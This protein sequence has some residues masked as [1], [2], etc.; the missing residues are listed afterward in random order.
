MCNSKLKSVGPV[1]LS[2][3]L[4]GIG[5]CS[6][7]TA[8]GDGPTVPMRPVEN[9]ALSEEYD[10]MPTPSDVLA[11]VIPRFAGRYVE[12]GVVKVLIAGEP[13]SQ[14]EGESARSAVRLVLDSIGQVGRK[15]EF[16]SGKYDFIQFRI[17]EK[18]LSKLNR[19]VGMISMG[20]QQKNQR[21]W[22]QVTSEDGKRKLL[23]SLESLHIPQEAV[24]VEVREQLI[25]Y[26]TTI[27]KI[28]P[29]RAGSQLTI[30][31]G[32]S[33]G[34]TNV[35]TSGFNVMHSVQV[36]VLT[37]AHCVVG[38]PYPFGGY[39]ADQRYNQPVE[40]PFNANR[41]ARV[42]HNPASSSSLPG[43][44]PGDVCRYSDAA[45]AII[46]SPIGDFDLFGMIRTTNRELV[47]GVAGSLNINTSSPRIPVVG[48]FVYSEGDTIDKIGKSTGWTAGEVIAECV[49]AY[50]AKDNGGRLCSGAVSAGS[51]PGD[52]G[53]PVFIWD[54][55]ENTAL[56]VGILFGGG[57]P[58][59]SGTSDHFLFSPVAGINQDFSASFP[60][61]FLFGY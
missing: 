14:L 46:T 55:V 13:L 26:Q 11:T 8:E 27:S 5:A 39:A 12:S 49:Y 51:G 33:S 54:S 57:V 22:I 24:N 25:P 1:I 41:F 44:W 42:T 37:V 56:A 34:S 9:V 36:Y 15:F 40:A 60:S 30:R 35:C 23:N 43:C 20:L 4:F 45:A 2:L 19:D 32:P 52:S 17:W 31:Y 61:G 7:I 47:P 3:L 18:R 10:V 48:T 59:P 50:I 53:A 58:G 21:L 28:R 6:D 38:S 16:A 29:I